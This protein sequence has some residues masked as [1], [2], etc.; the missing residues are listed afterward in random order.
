MR[1][2][3]NAASPSWSIGLLKYP[4]FCYKQ[5]L[6]KDRVTALLRA[7]YNKLNGLLP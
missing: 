7:S 4:N 1:K 2:E 6:S 5:D 3:V